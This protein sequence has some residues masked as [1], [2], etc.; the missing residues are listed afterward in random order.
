MSDPGEGKFLYSLDD[1]N[2]GA[3]IPIA[4]NADEYAV[5]YKTAGDE[6][7]LNVVVSLIAT[8]H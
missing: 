5:Y 8:S 3:E 1:E 6:K 7:N 4:I 2:F